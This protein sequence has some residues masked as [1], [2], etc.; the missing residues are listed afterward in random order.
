MSAKITLYVLLR[1][2]RL[3]RPAP[4]R[5]WTTDATTLHQEL[6]Q[7]L[8]PAPAAVQVDLVVQRSVQS[9]WSGVGYG[10]STDGGGS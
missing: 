6:H 8:A 10:G 2:G 1:N 9:Q 7:L 3:I 5:P 4:L